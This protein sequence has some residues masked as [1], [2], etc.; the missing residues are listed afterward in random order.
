MFGAAAFHIMRLFYGVTTHGPDDG[1]FEDLA[2]MPDEL[3]G[4]NRDHKGT[5]RPRHVR[6]FPKALWQ[7]IE[8]HGRSRV[9]L[10]V[11]WVFNAFAVDNCGNLDLTSNT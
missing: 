1:L 8:E 6:N 11:H 5:V 7:L 10:G 3:N 2:F 9:Y 4:V